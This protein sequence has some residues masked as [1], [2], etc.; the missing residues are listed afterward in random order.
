MRDFIEDDDDKYLPHADD[1]EVNSNILTR[2]NLNE[3]VC[4]RGAKFTDICIQPGIRILNG[5]VTCD[6]LGN[7]T[8][9]TPR[10]SITVDYFLASQ[11]LLQ[12]ISFIHVDKFYSD[13][14]YH[15]QI[16]LMLKVHCD[17]FSQHTII[18]LST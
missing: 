12:P 11:E 17:N 15:C 3:T 13:L 7:L 1:Y 5:R 2:N 9:H 10:G 14:S 16:S 18:N 4:L 8:C 6:W